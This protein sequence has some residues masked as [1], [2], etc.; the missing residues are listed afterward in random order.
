MRL[1]AALTDWDW[2]SFLRDRPEFDEVNFWSPSAATGFKALEPGELFAFKLHAPRSRIAGVAWYQGFCRLPLIGAWATFGEANGASSL[3][4]LTARIA[5]YRRGP[6]V[7]ERDQ[8]GCVLLRNPVFFPKDAWIAEPPDWSRNIVRGKGYD[9]AVG[10]GR[11]LWES[12]EERV[13][14]TTVELAAGLGPAA[15]P[16][17]FQEVTAM[18]RL[19]QRAFRA[20]VTDVY[21]RRCAVTG[22]RVLPVLDACHIRPATQEGPHD[23]RNGLLLRSDLHTLFDRGYLGVDPPT[24]RLLVSRQLRN[25]WKN[26]RDYYSLAGLELRSP[27][28]R[29]ESP[30]PEYLEWH[31]EV[32]F[33]G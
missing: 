18:R 7:A 24:H 17:E 1:F 10:I 30:A 8:V 4:E 15:D 5:R 16:V 9:A 3:P 31:R 21:D 6:V 12:L 20:L 33:R 13:R 14:S 22:E 2:F 32:L 25:D 29:A 11:V 27:R 19:G 26:G 28:D 23:I